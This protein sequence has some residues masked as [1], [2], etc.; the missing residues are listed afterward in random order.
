MKVTYYLEVISSWCHWAEPTWAELQARYASRVQFAWRIALMRP[1]D[2]PV[3]PAQADWFYR[4]S[5]T[6]ARS[7]Y[8]LN[9]GWFEAPG[10]DYATVN[11]VAEAARSL[12]ATGDTVRLALNHAAVREGRKINR[13]DEA[14]AIAATAGQLDPAQLRAR[15]ISPEIRATVDASTA[16]FHAL[17]ITQRPAFVLDDPIGDRAVFS[18]LI[19]LAPLTATI[20]AMLADTAA[21]ATHRAHFGDPP[22]I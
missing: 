4:R 22:T 5:G 13:L 8:M 20:D 16:A 17:Q 18:G 12:G 9:H 2:F 15:A 10:C 19:Q 1:Q 7:P 14:V 3:S 21:Y 6:I 11:L